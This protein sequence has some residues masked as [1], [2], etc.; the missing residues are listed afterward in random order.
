MRSAFRFSM[1]CSFHEKAEN[2]GNLQLALGVEEIVKCSE[3][4]VCC[5]VG[6]L[7]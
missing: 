7:E 1:L 5:E 4:V 6:T 3:W 2:L